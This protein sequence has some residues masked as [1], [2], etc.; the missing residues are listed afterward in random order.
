MKV[1]GS[2]GPIQ[3]ATEG[4]SEVQRTHQM[5]NHWQGAGVTKGELSCMFEERSIL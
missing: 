4:V 3:P 1:F 2:R 5:T